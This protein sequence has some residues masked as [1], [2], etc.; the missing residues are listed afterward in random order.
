MTRDKSGKLRDTGVRFQDIAGMEGL[1]FEMREIVKMLLKDPVY[2]RV[3]ARCPKVTPTTACIMC[4]VVG[5]SLCV[6]AHW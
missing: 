4:I 1:V 5:R 3:G 2:M 6:I